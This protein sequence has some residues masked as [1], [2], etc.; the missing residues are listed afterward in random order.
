MLLFSRNASYLYLLSTTQIMCN[1][2]HKTKCQQK[3]S[4][5]FNKLHWHLPGRRAQRLQLQPY[6]E[7]LQQGASYEQ[8]CW[9]QISQNQGELKDSPIGA[10]TKPASRGK[11]K[12]YMN[13]G[14]TIKQGHPG[15]SNSMVV[16]TIMLPPMLSY[17]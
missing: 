4:Q 11:Q 13:V 16:I 8:K 17:C 15:T 3:R 9:R 2:M 1:I 10:A 12:N 5:K 14:Q 6:F 7:Q